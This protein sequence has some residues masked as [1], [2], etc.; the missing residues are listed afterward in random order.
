[1]AKVMLICGKIAS[2]K[3]VYAE[4]LKKSENAV[5]LSVD[6]L[7]LSALGNDLGDRHDEITDRIQAYFFE[8][9][10]EII[11][12]GTNVLLDWGFW[13]KEKRRAARAFYES[14]G[15]GCEFHYIDT[16]HDVW[17]K[18]I[19]LRNAAVLSGRSDAYFVDEGLM[20]KLQSLFETPQ[21][22]EIDV[23]HVNDWR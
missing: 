15:I 8:K 16:P 21:R 4:M 19:E 5:L 12:A 9:S 10:L 18:N 17:L 23:G 14:R 1:M 2:G 7:V 11:A 22:E 6:E 13:T 3:S 20:I